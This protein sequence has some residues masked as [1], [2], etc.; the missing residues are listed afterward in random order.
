LL[1]EIG[2]EVRGLVAVAIGRAGAG[3]EE[4]GGEFVLDAVGRRKGREEEFAF[5]VEGV[6]AGEGDLE[7]GGCG[8]LFRR[9]L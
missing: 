5:E 8:G 7:G 6:G 9:G 2:D 4:D 3:E 1:Q